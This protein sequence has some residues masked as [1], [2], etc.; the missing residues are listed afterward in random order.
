MS[1]VDVVVVVDSSTRSLKKEASLKDRNSK[2]D[3]KLKT[4]EDEYEAKAKEIHE[5][6]GNSLMIKKKNDDDKEE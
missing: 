4:A 1:F 3:R 5:S 2:E 6:M